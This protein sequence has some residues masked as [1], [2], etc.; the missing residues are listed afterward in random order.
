MNLLFL[1]LIAF[2]FSYLNI[3][4]SKKVAESK[5]VFEVINHQA[6]NVNDIPLEIYQKEKLIAKFHT[7]KLTAISLPV[8]NYEFKVFYCDEVYTIK[9]TLSQSQHHLVFVLDEKECKDPILLL[10]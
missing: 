6:E 1:L 4:N 10:K 5:V 3:S 9:T 7:K 2:Q 8:E